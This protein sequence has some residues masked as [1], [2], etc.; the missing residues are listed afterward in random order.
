MQALVRLRILMFYQDDPK[1]CTAAR[2]IRIGRA[3]SIKRLGHD[4]IILDP[5][6]AGVLMPEDHQYANPLIGIDCSWRLAE[7]MF[8][9]DRRKNTDVANITT[10]TN[11]N[12]RRRLPPLLAGNPVNYARVGMLSTVEALAASLIIIGHKKQG[13][14]LLDGFRWG[15]TFLEL[16]S[17]ILE[18]YALMK[19]QEDVKR[20]VGDYRLC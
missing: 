17:N 1:K 20:I 16:N 14:E 3:R 8:Q 9:R 12:R 15:H 7:K 19:S 13:A 10:H 11:M 5:F 2:L 4:G 6:A 18:E